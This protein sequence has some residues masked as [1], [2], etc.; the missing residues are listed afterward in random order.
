M[1]T[2]LKEWAVLVDAMA[3]GDII[4]LVRKGGIREQRAGFSVR[5]QRFLLYPTYFHER[6]GELAPRFVAALPAS[7]AHQPPGGLV[8]LRYVADAAAVWRVSALE[9]LHAIEMEYGLSWSAVQSRFAYRNAPGVHVIAA[10][11]AQLPEE[12]EIPEARRYGGCVSWVALD[13]GVEVANATPVM[14]TQ[15]FAQRLAQLREALGDPL[16]APGDV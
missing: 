1:R 13:H 12:L 6:E 11:V 3:R 4:A 7:H 16:P 2:A 10:R 9:P 5:H 15:P 14:P 8:R